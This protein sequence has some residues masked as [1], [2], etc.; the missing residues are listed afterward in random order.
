MKQRNI[1]NLYLV[2]RY[3][4][5]KLPE[6]IKSIYGVG[7]IV[8]QIAPSAS[9]RELTK[10]INV[11]CVNQDYIS[12]ATKLRDMVFLVHVIINARITVFM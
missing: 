6:K 1:G 9:K 7:S 3:I 11:Q 10:I 5:I 8:I 12:T 4:W 2:S